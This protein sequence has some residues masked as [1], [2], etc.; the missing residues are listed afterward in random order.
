MSNYIIKDGELYHAGIKGM[1]WGVRRYQNE[2]GSLTDAGKKRY[3]KYTDKAAAYRKSSESY[4]KKSRD[5]L[6]KAHFTKSRDYD[7]AATR[8]EKKAEKYEEKAYRVTNPYTT[9]EKAARAIRKGS[10]IAANLAVASIADDM[11]Y[12]GAGKRAV[13]KAAITTGRAIVSAVV[14]AKGGRNIRWYDT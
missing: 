2:D 12:G 7:V 1:R 9:K 13:K 5:E 4:K 10:T 8:R 6:S 14:Y 3:N 11:L